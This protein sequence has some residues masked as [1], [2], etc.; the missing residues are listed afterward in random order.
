MIICKMSLAHFKSHRE[1]PKEAWRS[2][3]KCHPERSEGSK[4]LHFVQNDLRSDCHVPRLPINLY[5]EKLGLSWLPIN[6]K[7]SQDVALR[8]PRNDCMKWDGPETC[9][10]KEERNVPFEFVDFGFVSDFAPS[11]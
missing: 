1:P 5:N 9:P 6:L 2:D 8:A 4:I 10:G 3:K 7:E 11:F